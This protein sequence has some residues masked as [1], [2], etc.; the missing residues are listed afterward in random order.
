ML[1]ATT[2]CQRMGI[3]VRLR[4]MFLISIVYGSR[5][6]S[7]RVK[8]KNKVIRC[9]IKMR[10]SWRFFFFSARKKVLIW[11]ESLQNKFIATIVNWKLRGKQMKWGQFRKM[12]F[13]QF[14]IEASDCVPCFKLKKCFVPFHQFCFPF[15]VVCCY[16]DEDGQDLICTVQIVCDNPRRDR[17]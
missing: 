11:F 3:A 8:L 4:V 9:V 10:Q 1:T 5:K 14:R 2:K 16:C 12:P 15:S 17:G 6:W 7:C 13:I